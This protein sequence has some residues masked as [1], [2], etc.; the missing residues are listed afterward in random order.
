MLQKAKQKDKGGNKKGG[1]IRWCA[2][3]R[4]HPHKGMR[5]RGSITNYLIQEIFHTMDKN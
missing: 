4:W 3:E 5:E 2:H 1:K